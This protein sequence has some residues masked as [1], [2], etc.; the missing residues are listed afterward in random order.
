MIVAAN[1]LHATV[2]LRR[3]F[4][5][6]SRLLAP[7]GLLVM[8]EMIRPQRFIDI[9]FGLTEGWWKFTDTDLRPA[10][11]LLDRAGWLRFLADQ[12]FAEPQAVPAVDTPGHEQPRSS[13]PSSRR[14]HRSPRAD[15]VQLPDGQRRWLMLA[16]ADGVGRR[17]GDCSSIVAATSWW[18]RPPRRT[19]A[20]MTAA[21]SSTRRVATTSRC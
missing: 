7:G 16:D 13:R 14:A 18:R 5:H 11:L 10:S 2:D 12:G 21:S 17:L 9:S 20:S 8:V 15:A 1:V 4:D 6:V 19:G 3:T